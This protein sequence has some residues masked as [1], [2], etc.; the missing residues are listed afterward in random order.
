MASVRP[1]S[2]VTVSIWRITAGVGLLLGCGLAVR[3]SAIALSMGLWSGDWKWTTTGRSPADGWGADGW[4]AVWAS[5][6]NRLGSANC[7]CGCADDCTS[8][9]NDAG[10][11]YG[12]CWSDALGTGGSASIALALA[13]TARPARHPA[14]ARRRSQRILLWWAFMGTS[15]GFSV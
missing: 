8:V 9:W 15:L 1:P 2:L 14:S 6:W 12:C 3:R 13:G 5:V 7:F 4:G 11:V 10:S